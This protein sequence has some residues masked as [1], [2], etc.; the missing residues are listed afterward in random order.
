MSPVPHSEL[1]A[2][3]HVVQVVVVDASSSREVVRWAYDKDT[4][5]GDVSNVFSFENMFV[6][7]ALKD[8]YPAGYAPLDMLRQYAETMVRRDKKA[9]ML[10]KSLDETMSKTTDLSQIA[11]KYGAEVDTLSVSFADRNLGHYGAEAEVIGKL[12]GQAE[13]NK[14]MVSKGEMGVYVLCPVSFKQPEAMS[15]AGDR[16][17]K[18]NSYVERQKMMTQN[19]MSQGLTATLRKMYK[20]S[21]YRAKVF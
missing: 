11:A 12:F 17:E 21:D 14:Q 13:A 15:A 7:A 10:Q 8:I 3:V 6:V 1:L 20:L 18:L 4:K 19:Q 2:D 9:E 5:K 16:S